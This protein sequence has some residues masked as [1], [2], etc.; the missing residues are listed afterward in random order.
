MRIPF[1]PFLKISPLKDIQEHSEKIKECTW[2]FQQSMECYT[3]DKCLRFEEQKSE[4]L[5]LEEEANVIKRRIR[6]HIPKGAVLPVSKFQL[7]IYLKEQDKILVSVRNALKWLSYN[8]DAKIPDELRKDF[9]LL[10]DSVIDPIEELSEMVHEARKYF[11]KQND[12]NQAAVKKII[13]RIRDMKRE[14]DIIEDRFKH[15][16]FKLVDEPIMLFHLIKL[17]E[18]IG[19]IAAHSENAGDMMRAMIARS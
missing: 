13:V 12:K 4:V 3:I 2:A 15:E 7:F 17:T 19:S 1:V 9:L 11:K 14:A 16:I 6:G 8:S 18:I 5:K 10:L